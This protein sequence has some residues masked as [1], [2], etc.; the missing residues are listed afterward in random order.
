MWITIKMQPDL[1]NKFGSLSILEYNNT[2]VGGS[3]FSSFKFDCV[4]F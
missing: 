2:F 1:L 3:L 4:I